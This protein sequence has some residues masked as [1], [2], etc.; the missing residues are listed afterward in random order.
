VKQQM[1][2]ARTRVT[3]A[4]AAVAALGLAACGGSSSSPGTSTSAGSS[5]STSAASVAEFN[6]AV[7]K[8]FNASTTKGGTLRMANSGDWDSLDP[9]DTY[10]A[11]SW[12]FIRLYGRQ[13]VMFAPKPGKE[14][15]TLVPD[16]AEALGVPSDNAKTWTY[17]LRKGVKFED[18]TVVTSK[19]VK[20]AV[21]RSLDKTTFPNGPTYFNDFLDL[22]GYTSPYKDTTPGKLGLKAITTPDDSTI[23]F[24]LNKPFSGFDYFAQLPATIPVP[25]AKDTGTKYK[26]HVVSTGP[27]M[28][29]SV[30]SG[31][32][33]TLKRNPSWDAATD[34][35]RAALPDRIEVELAANA[36]DIDN[37]L[38]SGNL[39]VGVE[40][41]GVQ[42]AAQGKILS[43]PKL[44][45][46]ADSAAI[47]RLFYT[48]INGEVAPLDNIHCRKA[49]EYAADKTG[50]QRA[51]GGATG[52]DIA[53]NVMPPVIPGAT[54]FNDYPG[55]SD[56]TG[57]LTKAKDELTQCGQPNGFETSISYRTERPKE[58]A[59]SEALQQSLGRVGIKLTIKPY[60]AGDYYKLY[61]GKPDYAKTNKLGLMVSGWQADWPDGFGMQS[62]IVDSRVIRAAGGN[63]N[64]TVKDP[65]VDKL[66]DTALITT[67]TAGRQ[68]AWAAVDKQVMDT[69]FI[70]PGV[71][72]KGLLYR[73][74]TLTNVFITDGFGM[75]DYLALGVASK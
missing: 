43:D 41:T 39:D 36:D 37:R 57:D 19:D 9:A 68:A 71:W 67:D 47:P 21:E 54:S 23:V 16:L 51:Y 30:A 5:A 34:P 26:E 15:A 61:A 4:V 1:K 14:G 66:I 56:N 2:Q 31:K 45:A 24:H 35:N 75:Y 62:Q 74:S 10:Y 22:Q 50:Y 44:K 48:A 72:A 38:I 73:P 20:Y 12:N 6:A 13:L 8:V 49:V 55:G 63:T 52:G 60:P 69:A 29:D 42:A 53:T 28:F 27:Y 11:Y 70:L 17:K 58:K 7:G 59:V 46:N 33:I 18:G 25:V 65:Q 64:L 32:K 40:G 3:V